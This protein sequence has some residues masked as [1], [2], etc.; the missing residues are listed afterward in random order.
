MD[1]AISLVESFLRLH[2]YLTVSEWQVV[3]RNDRGQWDTVTDIDVLAVRFPHN[4][5]LADSHDPGEKETLIVTSDVLGVAEDAVDVIVG[6][7]KQG[8]A[9]FNPSLSR[10]EPIHVA[11]SRLSWLYP[12][13]V[14][15]AVVSDLAQ[16]GVCHSVASDG[17]AVRTRLVAFGRAQRGDLNTVP[18]GALMKELADLLSSKADVLKS[19]R[20]SAEA[21]ATLQ[22]MVKTG[23]DVRWNRTDG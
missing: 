12:A 14:M 18:I 7:V 2:G 20:F 15:D 8:E 22:L 6:E 10:H 21:L 5:M 11:L 17:T 16:R 9:V 23:F 4:A 1:A 19:V 3:G 13:D